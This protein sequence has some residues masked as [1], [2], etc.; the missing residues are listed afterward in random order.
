MV[1]LNETEEDKVLEEALVIFKE[2]LDNKI[3]VSPSKD[4]LDTIVKTT[5]KLENPNLYELPN[6]SHWLV[7][8]EHN[9][10]STH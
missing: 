7:L 1:L 10:T 8:M 9:N 3:L 6:I 4:L 2:A 5:V